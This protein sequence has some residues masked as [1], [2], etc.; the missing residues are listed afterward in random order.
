MRHLRI[1][2]LHRRCCRNITFLTAGDTVSLSSSVYAEVLWPT[3]DLK[4]KDDNSGS[5]VLNVVYNGYSVLMMADLQDKYDAQA[6]KDA[7]TVKIAHH[8][9]KNATTAAMLDIVTPE[10]A[11]ISVGNNGFGHPTKEVLDRIANV[12]AT[13]YRTDELGAITMDIFPDGSTQISTVLPVNN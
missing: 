11:I 3:M 5:L 8:G 6:C 10:I 7:D 1:I 4:L 9:S 2:T 13:V 12:N